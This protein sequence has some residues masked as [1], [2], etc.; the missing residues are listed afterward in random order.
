MFVQKNL[1]TYWIHHVITRLEF[2]P[3]RSISPKV[4]VVV[5]LQ[6]ELSDYGVIDQYVSH[7]T[8]G[9]LLDE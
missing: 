8:M 3:A 7:Y 1:E 6:I 4:N 5:R 2:E 9:S